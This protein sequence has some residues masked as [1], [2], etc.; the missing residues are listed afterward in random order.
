VKEL[1]MSKRSTRSL[2]T[3]IVLSSALASITGCSTSSTSQT[4][5]AYVDDTVI[6]TKVKAK[7][8]EAKEVDAT[9]IGVETI[10]GTVLLRG[11]A[12]SPQEKRQAEIIARSI[13]GV[14]A[15]NNRI[16]VTS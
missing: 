1:I 14:K 12:K 9:S 16:D 2:F 6:T 3:A 11:M 7:F 13:D 4:V 8:A 5:G 10:N 15:V